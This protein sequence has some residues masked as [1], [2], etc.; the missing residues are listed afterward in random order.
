MNTNNGAPPPA[1]VIFHKNGPFHFRVDTCSYQHGELSTEQLRAQ[2]LFLRLESDDSFFQ[3]RFLSKAED[4][5]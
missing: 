5:R 4:S 1:S 3:A 2:R